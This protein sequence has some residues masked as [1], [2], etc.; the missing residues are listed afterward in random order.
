MARQIVEVFAMIKFI[1][2]IIIEEV[3]APAFAYGLI[4][5]LIALAAIATLVT[6][7]GA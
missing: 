6:M 7:G 3:G 4:A 5:V 1:S 2:T